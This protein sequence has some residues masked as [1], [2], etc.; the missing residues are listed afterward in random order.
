MCEWVCV[1]PELSVDNIDNMG[2]DR[3]IHSDLQSE[4][5]MWS[6][7]TSLFLKRFSRWSGSSLVL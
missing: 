1:E 7:G 5:T 6:F 3:I 4:V 2:E